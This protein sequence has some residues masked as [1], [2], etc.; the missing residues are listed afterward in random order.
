M[1]L[2]LYLGGAYAYIDLSGSAPAKPTLAS[3]KALGIGGPQPTSAPKPSGVIEKRQQ[4]AN[5]CGYVS[6]DEGE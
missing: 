6:G 1:P 4:G 3:M 2:A 5:T